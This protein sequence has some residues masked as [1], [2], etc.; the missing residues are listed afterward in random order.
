[1]LMIYGLFVF[2]V[3]SS[4]FNEREHST[5]YRWASN[6]RV[7]LNPAYQYIGKG[8]DSITL[9][10]TLMPEFSGGPLSLSMLRMLADSGQAYLLMSGSGHIF[11]Y[12]F[13]EE[14]SDNSSHFLRDGTP[15]K[16]EFTISLKRYDGELTG[17]VGSLAPL[18]P[19]INKVF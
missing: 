7:G 18:I 19:M 4:P 2:S 3:Q 5:Q 1:M 8:E 11:G 10:G 6:N 14:I 15:Q 13:I 12:Y 17:M 16:I 9:T